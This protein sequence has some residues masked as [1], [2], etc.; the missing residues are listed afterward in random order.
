MG[1]NDH[2]HTEQIGFVP[3]N[4]MGPGYRAVKALVDRHADATGYSAADEAAE[5][6]C[7]RCQ[8]AFDIVIHQPQPPKADPLIGIGGAPTRATTLPT[9]AKDL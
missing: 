5:D 9:D 6:E 4:K 7:D 3:E 2:L 1:H 8:A